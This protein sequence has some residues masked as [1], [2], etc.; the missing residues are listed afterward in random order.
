[1]SQRKQTAIVTGSTSGIGLAVARALVD[2][3]DNIVLNGRDPK[4]LRQAQDDLGAPEQV[5]GVAGNIGQRR[6]GSA[7]ARTAIERFG[8]VDILVNNA[9]TFAPNAFLD[10]AEEELDGYLQGNLKGTYLTTQAVVREM[11]QR[12]SGSIVNIGTVLI[13]HAIGG[14]PASAPLV[15]KGGVHALTVSLAAELAP[16]GIRV[17]AVAPGVIRTPLHGNAD[18]DSFGG[19]ALL[20]RVGEV[21]E[22]TQAVL[23]LADAT[24]TTGHILPVDGGFVTGRRLAA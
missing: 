4:R 16:Y 12:R 23:Y 7:L 20:N 1:M 6:T 15:S 8:S 9:G 13:D 21:D 11:K 2:R 18:V 22:I 17:N 10:V 24:F 3:G 14:F 5:A 19:V